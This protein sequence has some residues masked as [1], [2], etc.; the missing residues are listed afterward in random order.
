[1]TIAAVHVHRLVAPLHTPF[2]TALAHLTHV[3]TVVVEIVDRDGRSGFGEARS[4]PAP[5]PAW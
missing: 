5:R 4:A 2:V 3:S 1:M